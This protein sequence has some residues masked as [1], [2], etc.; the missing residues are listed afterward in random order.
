MHGNRLLRYSWICLLLSGLG[1]RP[2]QAHDENKNIII[3]EQS[4]GCE[5][6]DKTQP[7]PFRIELSAKQ[8]TLEEDVEMVLSVYLDADLALED[9]W[10]C[11]PE[12]MREWML[13]TDSDNLRAWLL[14]INNPDEPYGIVIKCGQV[15]ADSI[16]VDLIDAQEPD[17][18]KGQELIA[19]IPG[20]RTTIAYRR[21]WRE[22]LILAAYLP[23]Q[24]RFVA[25]GRGDY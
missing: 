15:H 23:E 16:E 12:D 10:K 5:A 8:A 13:Q 24:G 25:Y 1:C 6:D 3:R 17:A 21:T 18:K 7:R 20:T 11:P 22:D 14:K 4:F 2:E 9:R 19:T